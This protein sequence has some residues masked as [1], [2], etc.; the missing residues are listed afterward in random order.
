MELHEEKRN[1]FDYADKGVVLAH[2]IG[3]DL[4]MG[5]GI[6]V[7]MQKRFGIRG[8][9]RTLYGNTIPCPSCIY[10]KGVLNLITKQR[11]TGKPTH[12]SMYLALLAMRDSVIAEGIKE[13][14][15]PKIGCGLDR[16]SWARV[17]EDINSAFADVDV[18]ITV[19]KL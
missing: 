1:V 15:M 6:A 17:R 2:C 8:K 10:T 11:S 9:I 7:P 4:L 14:A 16:L 5:A 13:I 3:A 12:G 18:V 19:C